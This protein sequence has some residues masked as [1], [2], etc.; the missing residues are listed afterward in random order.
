MG[1]DIPHLVSDPVSSLKAAAEATLLKLT[2]SKVAARGRGYEAGRAYV[3]C[4]EQA[5][6]VSGQRCLA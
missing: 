6:K 2:S 5:H 4:G 1:G 3:L